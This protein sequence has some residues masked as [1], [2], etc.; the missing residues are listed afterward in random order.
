MKKPKKAHA[1]E[2]SKK[3]VIYQVRSMEVLSQGEE[4][5]NEKRKV[6]QLY[7][8]D[9]DYISLQ[10][11]EKKEMCGARIIVCFYTSKSLLDTEAKI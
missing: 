1:L 7:V 8:A 9:K 4:E 3:A 6:K 10:Y 11:K 5:V 2:M